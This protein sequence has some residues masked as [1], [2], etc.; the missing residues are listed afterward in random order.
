MPPPRHKAACR[1]RPEI[2][3]CIAAP[4]IAID[5]AILWPWLKHAFELLLEARE[6]AAA[7]DQVAIASGPSRVRLGV[8]VEGEGVAL[9]AVGGVGLKLGS[10]RHRH[11]DT[12]VVRVKIV[13]LL[14]CRLT[15]AAAAAM[16][17]KRV[18]PCTGTGAPGQAAEPGRE[19][20]QKWATAEFVTAP[21]HFCA[22]LAGA[23][24]FALLT[25]GRMPQVAPREPLRGL[26]TSGG[27]LCL[28]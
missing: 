7:I 14:H 5:P 25:R 22:I 16:P 27:Q 11:F 12:M 8:D 24:V 23:A 6:A 18:L 13:L 3:R 1:R 2:G 19:G 4:S 20:S 10:V 9:F 21:H 26:Q 28:A 17:A 15:G